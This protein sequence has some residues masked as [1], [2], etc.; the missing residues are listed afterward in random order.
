LY[1][2]LLAIKD[3]VYSQQLTVTGR[4]GGL[5]ALRATVR[6]RA[7]F[8]ARDCVEAGARG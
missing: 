8:V 2:G 5:C 6:R 4:V 1:T 7:V 3:S